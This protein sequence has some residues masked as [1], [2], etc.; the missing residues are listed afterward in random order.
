M[1]LQATALTVRYPGTTTPAL[2]GVSLALAPG[3]IVAVVGPNGSGKSTLLRALLGLLPL[4]AGAVT[5]NGRALASWSRRDLADVV[6][7]LPQ[8]EEST[9]PL[10]VLESVLLGRWSRLGP[11]ASVHGASRSNAKVGWRATTSA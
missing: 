1:T 8:R 9:F 6:G 3:E 11:V 10:T 2:D 7:A 5:L 4:T